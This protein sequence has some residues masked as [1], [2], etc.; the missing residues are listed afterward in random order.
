MRAAYFRSFYD[1]FICGVGAGIAY[2]FEYS[3][4][5]QV[6][7]LRYNSNISAEVVERYIFYIDIVDIYSAFLYII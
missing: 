1:F 7:L 5:E 6:G 3:P 4:G 2:I